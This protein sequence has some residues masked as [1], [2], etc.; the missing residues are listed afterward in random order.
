VYI[1]PSEAEPGGVGEV[2]VSTVAPALC[3]ALA[4]AGH[5]PRNLPIRNEGFSWV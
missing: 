4:A 1:I 5:R 3:N 2:G